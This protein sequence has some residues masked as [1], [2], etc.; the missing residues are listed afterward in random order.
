MAKPD[1][2][3]AA[4]DRPLISKDDLQFMLQLPWLWVV[5][6]WVPEHRWR[7]LCFAFERFKTNLN[8]FSTERVTKNAARALAGTATPFDPSTFAIQVAAGRSEHHLQIIRAARPGGWDA[9]IVLDGGEH[10][11]RAM[12]EGHGAVLWVAHFCFN[13]LATKMAVAA[14]GYKM[15]HLSRPE[16]GFSKSRF[17]IR[18]LNPLRCKVEQ[19]YAD[20]IIIRRE[21]PATATHAAQRR[22]RRNEVISITA[23][24]W[25]GKRTAHI[26]LLGGR[27][28]LAV[29]APSLAALTGAALLPVVTIRDG[30]NGPLRVMI[31]EPITPPADAPRNEAVAAM[32]DV[33]A[34]RIE[35]AILAHPEQWRDW[36][37]LSF[38]D[39]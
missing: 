21:S 33:F 31:G 6:W 20:R 4:P 39:A 27:L 38:D 13:A 9:N 28:K 18:C 17:G 3:S 32:T 15:S 5:A 24:A 16:H 30:D 19:R 2:K 35:P 11:E 7:R 34:D 26:E 37:S 10:L 1:K 8:F 36:K 29:G 12:T 14:T 23:G 25:E 22:L